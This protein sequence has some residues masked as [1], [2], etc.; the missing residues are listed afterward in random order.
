[1][2]VLSVA[3]D[4]VRNNRVAALIA[5]DAS[6]WVAAMYLATMLRLETL[7]AQPERAI[8]GTQGDVPLYGVLIVA[9]VAALV[10]GAAAWATRLHQGRSAL[11]SFDEIF[12]LATV[13]AVAGAAATIFNASLDLFMLPRATPVVA[14]FIALFF[15]TWPRGLWRLLV[16][17]PSRTRRGATAKSV[18]I[19]GA[20]EGG[21]QLVQSIQRDPR[22][23]WRV[24]GFV[25]DDPRKKHFRYRG[26]SVRGKID[27]LAAVADRTD[28]S[29][30][31]VAIPS[32]GPE[33]ISRINQLALEADLD[34]KVLP[35]LNEMMSAISV[36]SVRDLQPE[37]LLGRHQIKTDL[38]AISH[39]LTGKRVLVTGAGGSIGSELCRQIH[40]FDPASLV[41]LDRDESAMHTLLL[42]MHGRADLD[43]QD[44]V[45]ANIR[46]ADRM[47]EVFETHRP[48]VVFHAAA[49]KHVNMLETHAAEAVKTNVLGT[50][51][52]LQAAKEF[53]V[54]RF[55]NIST[56]KAADPI[57]VLGYTKRIAEGLTAAFATETSTGVYL[58]VRFGNVLGTNGSV[59][60]TFDSQIKAGGPV[61][62]T[63][64]EVTRY[65]MTVDEAVQLVVQASAIGRDGE[66]LVLDMGEP[67][68]ID[69]VARQLIEQSR[70]S[71]EIV[72]T[73]LKP[74]EKMHEVLFGTGEDDV[75]PVHPMV[76][77]VSVPPIPA[78]RC[79]VHRAAWMQRRRRHRRDRRW[80]LA[81][82]P[83]IVRTSSDGAHLALEPR[84]HAARGAVRR[85]RDP[86]WLG[87]TART[88]GRRVRG[89]DG[90]ARR[91]QARSGTQLGHGCTSPRARLVGRR[92]PATSSPP[93]R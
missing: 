12:V 27:R 81:C 92:A 73:G 74:G 10:H 35:G 72:Y 93:R 31:I 26:V 82:L 58:S 3:I 59:L 46:E 48:E 6:A 89:R 83:Q 91:R 45:L 29:S 20:G 40:R 52:L 49:L 28:A 17:D 80:P 55:V 77:H 64:P 15:C 25:D 75:R 43:S 70:E 50:L 24:V 51:N 66:A 23:Q 8:A 36:G 71:V 4:T 62:V 32:A 53:G 1:M 2:H 41:M 14:T 76:S 38:Q 34:I 22:E 61:T 16:A 18:L 5:V 86:L 84:H 65:F 79:S 87:G 68:S 42:S 90:R 7:G 78:A 44:V 60:R 88:P 39:T 33:L 11:G 85:R 19:V 21:R 57:N 13:L 67:I 37:D 47:R 54:E 69:G 56:D 9:A 30:V 63:H